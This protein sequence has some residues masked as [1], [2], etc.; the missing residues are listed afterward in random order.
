MNDDVTELTDELGGCIRVAVL[1][2]WQD[3]VVIT[4]S[5]GTIAAVTLNAQQAKAL[6][7]ALID[8]GF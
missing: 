6:A 2:K 5:D 3:G 1:P 8:A 4:V 7:N